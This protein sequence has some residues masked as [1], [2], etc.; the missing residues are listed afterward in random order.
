MEEARGH[1][2][3]AI[4]NIQQRALKEQEGISIQLDITMMSMLF[5]KMEMVEVCGP[6][7]VAEM[8]RKMGLKVGWSLDMTTHG[9]DGK[10]WDFNNTE[11]RNRAARKVLRDEPLLLIGS[12][13]CTVFSVMNDV[14]YVKTSAE[15]VEQRKEYGRKRL[16]FYGQVYA[17]QW[18]S[19]RY[20]LHGHPGSA[21]SWHEECIM[22][23]FNKEGVLRVNGDQC[24]YGLKSNDGIREGPAR[25]GIGFMTTPVCIAQRLQR[26]CP[27]RKGEHAHRHMTL[28]NGRTRVAQAY[29]PGLCKLIC[30]GLQEQI[31]IDARGHFCY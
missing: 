13:M 9:F 17:I 20:F 6:P 18:R 2:R 16:R 24:M 3:K 12:P 23:I 4:Y 22:N 14:N 11:M 28:E 29:P 8:V 19:G 31:T 30:E 5:D 15:E 26:R 25:K 21:S 1:A 7:S 10:R 27:N